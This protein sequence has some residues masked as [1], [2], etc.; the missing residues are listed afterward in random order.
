MYVKIPE[1]FWS[2]VHR[3][4]PNKDDAMSFQRFKT[5]SAR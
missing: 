5:L 4:S 1:I 3:P 2:A